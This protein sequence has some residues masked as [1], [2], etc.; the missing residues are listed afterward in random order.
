MRAILYHGMPRS[1]AKLRGRSIA[2]VS[3]GIEE[4]AVITAP[5]CGTVASGLVFK[6]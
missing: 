1:L 3:C 5:S 4:N 2:A 6:S